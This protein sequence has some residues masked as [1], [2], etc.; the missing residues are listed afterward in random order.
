MVL[1]CMEALSNMTISL[2]RPLI[3]SR[4]CDFKLWVTKL[5]TQRMLDKRTLNRKVSN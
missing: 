1:L 4:L 2:D 3:L 5:S